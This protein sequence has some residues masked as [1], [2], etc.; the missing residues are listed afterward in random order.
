MGRTLATADDDAILS[1]LC[2]GARG[3]RA[4]LR[5]LWQAPPLKDPRNRNSGAGPHGP[6]GRGGFDM[7]PG[8]RPGSHTTAGRTAEED[9]VRVR[10]A[11]RGAEPTAGPN[12][13]RTAGRGAAEAARTGVRRTPDRRPTAVTTTP[14]AAADS[15]RR[16][17][18]ATG[19][20]STAIGSTAAGDFTA[21]GSPIRTPAVRVAT[22]P[23][24]DEH[25]TGGAAAHAT[26]RS[27]ARAASS[28][29][30]RG[31]RA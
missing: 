4:S 3:R 29:D 1:I 30:E 23:G 21:A 19:G 2:P 7:G 9:D 26:P 24:A 16:A 14:D 6:A 27:A 20:N 8:S 11:G 15:G 25:P 17:A 18:F 12:S 28:R 10:R 22:D 5:L 13:R 31:H